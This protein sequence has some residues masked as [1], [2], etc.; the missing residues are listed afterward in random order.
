MERR[1]VNFFLTFEMFAKNS[2]NIVLI[3]EP[4]KSK[5]KFTLYDS[6]IGGLP[7]IA[8]CMDNPIALVY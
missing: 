6:K 1:S 2:N 5:E 3:G 8:L 7:V 4:Y